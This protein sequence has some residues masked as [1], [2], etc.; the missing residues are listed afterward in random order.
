MIKLG[1]VMDPIAHINIKKDTSFAMLLEAQRRG[2]ELHYMEMA[3]LY[4]INGEA[5]ART[6][7]LSVEQNY[8]KWYEFGS[9]QEIKLAD[10]DV[11]L[12]R[13]DP[14]FDTEFIYATYIL[15]RAEEE[16]TLIVNKPQSLRDCNEKLYTA[17]FSDLTPETLV[18]R[19]KAQ[20]KAFWEKHGDI[21]MKPLD[22]M[23]GASIFRVKE[24]DPNIGVIAETLTELG[25][26][27]C[28]AQNYLPAI[29]DG[30][31][32]VLVVDGE[33]VPYCLAR[34]P[35]GG[36]TRGN[37]AA[38]GRG[39]PRPLS[40]SNWEIARRVG[41]TLKAKGLIFVGLDIIGDRLTEINVTSPTCVREIEAEYPISIT[42]ML[43][44][45]IE[46][47]LAK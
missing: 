23:G 42:G 43:M 7:T 36:E 33:P 30:D 15:E 29:K 32:R 39:E 9:E 37:L 14:P 44:D 8:D 25:N 41:P 45:A 3:D 13:K 27:Y 46:A 22:G 40:E 28:M 16:G 31:K 12:M 21:I 24:G 38:G 26:R 35:Q 5:R 1:I 2:Y 17:W 34:I 6:R 19:N 18:T 11:I 10:L 4:L 20:L 47:R